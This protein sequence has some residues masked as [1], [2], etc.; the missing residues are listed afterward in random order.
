MKG[1]ILMKNKTFTLAV[2]A[3]TCFAGLGRAQLLNDNF[4][5]DSQLN[6]NLW[7][8]QSSLLYSLAAS[9]VPGD[10]LVP[11]ALG[12]A[13]S[14]MQM[15][16]V[17]G[18]NELTAI[19]SRSAFAPPFTLNTT[20]EGVAAY[21][22]PFEV[23]LVNS[24]LHQWFV[25]GGNVGSGNGVYYGMWANYT[26]SG[27]PIL[28]RGERLYYQP[29]IG[30]WYSLQISIDTNGNASVVLSANGA[31]LAAQGSLP[32][33]T[34][35]FYV[36]LAQREGVPAV[37]GPNVAIWQSLSLASGAA[38]LPVLLY[39]GEAPVWTANGFNLA[40]QGPVGNYLI[41]ASESLASPTN[42][43]VIQNYS[44]TNSSSNYYLTDTNATNCKQRFYRAV[45]Q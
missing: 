28:Y 25:I 44:I 34:G 8:N 10:A 6:T 18:T 17:S 33:G 42:W 2:V 30:V 9:D 36:I 13:P 32:V 26:T 19:Q 23:L 38:P 35:P 45:L 20:V 7:T 43:Q 1:E 22:Y 27:A 41:E 3:V 5:A 24:N 39:P 16:G 15:S 40:L 29:S 37:I 12:F 4:T 11:L 21:G 31:V 14:G